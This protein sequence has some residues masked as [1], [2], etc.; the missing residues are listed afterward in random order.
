MKKSIACLILVSMVVSVFALNCSAAELKTSITYFED[1]SY[2]I[3]T[4][5]MSRGRASGS[6]QGTRT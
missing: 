2:I 6:I 5:E 3:D 4:I 1:G